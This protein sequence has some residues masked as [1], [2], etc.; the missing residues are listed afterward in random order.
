MHLRSFSRRANYFISDPTHQHDDVYMKLLSLSLDIRDGEWY[1]N[2]L[3]NSFATL[4]TFKIVFI[5]RFVEKK[6]LGINWLH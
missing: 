2:L 6:A 1:K 3:E 4:T 5:N